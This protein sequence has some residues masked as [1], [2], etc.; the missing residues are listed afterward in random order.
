LF[1]GSCFR[2]REYGST[3]EAKELSTSIHTLE[4]AK[5]ADDGS[6]D[7][8]N[9]D[10]FLL[11]Q[12]LEKGV[13][14]AL[15]DKYLKGMTFAIMT[16]HPLTQ[17]EIVLEEYDFNLD[18]CSGEQ[19]EALINGVKIT[20]QS[21][22]DQANKFVR[23]LIE[24]SSTLDHIPDHRWITL[25]LSY[26]D[27]T[28][29]DYQPM[30][31]A[32]A[33][34]SL[35]LLIGEN[36]INIKIGKL[37]TPH[38][39]LDVEFKGVEN[40]D[41]LLESDLPTRSSLKAGT[42][43]ATPAAMSTFR[44][45]SAPRGV[46][47]SRNGVA[48]MP[49]SREEEARFTPST[50]GDSDEASAESPYEMVKAFLLQERKSVMVQVCQALPLSS[51]VVKR[52]F[53]QLLKEGFLKMNKRQ[54]VLADSVLSTLKQK[55]LASMSAPSAPRKVSRVLDDAATMEESAGEDEAEDATHLAASSIPVS[56]SASKGRRNLTKLTPE[57]SQR[58]VVPVSL[59]TP[60]AEGQPARRS[61]KRVI[62]ESEDISWSPEVRLPPA[63]KK[64]K[65]SIIKEPLHLYDQSL[66]Q[67]SDMDV[68]MVRADYSYSQYSQ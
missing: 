64:R 31:F 20:K 35:P 61:N 16:T 42:T 17:E 40:F 7:V 23:A 5:E 34:N 18:Y 53:I 36:S 63:A 1:P 33:T 2:K 3:K 58:N 30:F 15:V 21:L 26:I 67:K 14:E 29:A 48:D 24:F 57:T 68:E 25:Q 50:D 28:P 8:I 37:Q 56:A 52:Q 55:N 19:H 12:W 46:P 11:T 51:A 22:K 32:D 4:P 65:L 44:G 41:A 45:S 9:E 43:S 59:C 60:P 47:E 54:Y 66:S 49:E 13:F 6:I 62:P 27:E 10:A 38:H 39:R